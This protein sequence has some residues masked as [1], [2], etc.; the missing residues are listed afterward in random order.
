MQGVG[1]ID[2]EIRSGRIKY[3]LAIGA[4]VA[5]AERGD[6][7][8]Y[9]CGAG[10][11]AFVLGR[12]DLIATIEDIAPFSSLFMD[13]WRRDQAARSEERRVGKEGRAGWSGDHEKKK[14]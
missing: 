4:D 14:W 7:L 12:T 13:F 10:A 6:P 5:Q 8:E 1:F 2:S 3:G 11:G 9:S